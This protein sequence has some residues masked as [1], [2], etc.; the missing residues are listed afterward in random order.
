MYSLNRQTKIMQSTAYSKNSSLVFRISVLLILGFLFCSAGISQTISLSLKSASLEKAFREIESKIQQ[1]FVYTTEM[2]SDTKPVSLNVQNASLSILLDLLFKDQPLDYSFDDTFIRVR[3][4]TQSGSSPNNFDVHGIVATESGEPL[5]NVSVSAKLSGKFTV[6]DAQGRFLIKQVAEDEVLA[7]SSIGYSNKSVELNGLHFIEVQLSLSVSELDRALVIAYGTSS[8]RL[9][10]GN[11]AKVTSSDMARQPSPNPLSLLQGR[12][13]GVLVTQSNGL[14]GSTVKIEIRGRNSIAQGSSPL[15]IIDGVPF[16]P[17][18]A[19]LNQLSSAI[20][21]TSSVPSFS[22]GLSPFSLINPA[23]IESIEILKDADATAIYGSRGAN[24]VVLITTKKG[25]EGRPSLFLQLR[26]GWSKLAS[27]ISMLNTPQYL[28]MRREAFA[29]DNVSISTDPFSPGYAPDLLL[30]DTTRN[31]NFQKL[32]IGGTAKTTEALASYSGGFSGTTFLLSSAYRFQST[33][34]PGSS[35]DKQGSFHFNLNHNTPNK[36]FGATFSLDYTSDNNNLLKSD[37][38]SYLNLPPSLPSLKDASGNLKWEDA[39]AAYP[40]GNPLAEL[41]KTYSAQS[42]NLVSALALNYHL[43]PSFTVKTGLGYNTVLVNEQSLNPSSAFDP[44]LGAKGS[45]LFASGLVR[46]WVAEPQAEYIFSKGR[47]KFNTLI[48]ATFQEITNRQQSTAALDYANDLALQSIAAAGR[49]VASNSL[50]QYRYH[51]VF[52]R[53]GYNYNSKYLLNISG[54]RDGSSRFGPGKKWANF[55][56][57]GAAWIF[58]GERFAQDHL[59]FLSYGKLRGSYGSSGND[60]IGD[61]QYLDSWVSTSNPYQGIPGFVPARLFNAAYSWETNRKMEL[62]LELGFLQDRLFFSASA[63]RNRSANQLVSYPLPAQTGFSSINKNLPALVQN[64]GIELVLSYNSAP[65]HKL[66]WQSSFNFS[67]QKNK[68]VSFPGLSSSSYAA[69]Y[70]EG[71]PLSV[72]Q[73]FQ[74]LGVDPSSGIYA[75][76]D[77][78]KDGSLSYPADYLPFGNTD[79]S[80]FGGFSNTFSYKSFE[81]SFLIEFRKQL[82]RNYFD[83]FSSFPPGS[84]YNQPDY[85]LSRWQ[86]T[87]NKVP[88]QK[89]SASW[90]TPANSAIYNLLQSEALYSNASYIRGKNLSLSYNCHFKWPQDLDLRLYFQAVN[91]FTITNY[92]GTDPE[93]QNFYALPPLRSFVTG[94]S[95]NF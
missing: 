58:T 78:N 15:F 11:I 60:Q 29:N 9:S 21:V 39:G 24:G 34:F 70:I 27:G 7:F 52:G 2:L 28:Q 45:S 8:R 59:S 40:L 49:V 42:Q 50:S 6:T 53:I 4:K 41:L 13:P 18:N 17:G 74:F 20:G 14:P 35:A 80:F 87:G 84:M 5:A 47:S 72:L 46:S 73:G 38:S 77:V 37:L 76:E 31:T 85:I 57:V 88:V 51:A 86:T 10:T 43:F 12:V 67:H 16:A 79:P 66:G 61:Y 92:K 93:T 48:G 82:G 19:N 55:A 63:F 32:L 22:S 25:K 95:F 94:V 44:Q 3:L 83:I 30:W 68:L 71:Q 56:A 90:G 89:F 75:F 65:N 91:V 36:K 62:A 69:S 26:T 64:S 81:L 54:R 23:S 33:V 1:R